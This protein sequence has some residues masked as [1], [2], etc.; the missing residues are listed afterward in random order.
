MNGFVQAPHFPQDFRSPGVSEGRG[1][2]FG[3]AAQ[4]QG[5]GQGLDGCCVVA[6]GFLDKGALVVQSSRRVLREGAGS[7]VGA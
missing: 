6:E 1:A 3:G 5:N 7:A 4:A 2:G